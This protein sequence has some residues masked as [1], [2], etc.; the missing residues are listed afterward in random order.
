MTGTD[1]QRPHPHVPFLYEM[2][3][4]FFEVAKETLD[5]VLQSI[6]G[7]RELSVDRNGRPAPPDHVAR[8]LLELP[9]N[10]IVAHVGACL[11]ATT[12]LGLAYVHSLRLLSLL[13]QNT[14]SLPA[15]A[16]KPDLA[17]MF[18]ALP[19]R[20]RKALN[21]IHGK[22]ASHDFELEIATEPLPE[23]AEETETLKGR[24]FRSTLADWQA[25]KMLHESHLFRLGPGLGSAVRIF[26]PLRSLLMLDQIISDQIAPKLGRK[27]ETIAQ[28]MSNHAKGPELR[29]DEGMIHVS[30]PKRMGRTLEARWKP[31]V[32]TVVRI[33]RS[34]TATWTPGFETPFNTC[35]FVDLKPETEYEVQVTHKNE[36]G[37]SEPA[38]ASVTTHPGKH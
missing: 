25:K 21:E 9:P 4:S 1:T 14:D 8:K 22:V 18:D 32:T 16:A 34:G 20:S 3:M 5:P 11:S 24:D 23:E 2:T 35:S 30:L 17:N 12:S 28:R 33:R 7:Y 36:A 15:D 26:V 29:W 10:E 13:T 38:I 31:G 19:A 37:E 6:D 27:H